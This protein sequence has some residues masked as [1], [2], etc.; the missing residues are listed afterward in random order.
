MTV[1]DKLLR[2]REN[3]DNVRAAALARGKKE[4][5]ETGRK[6]EYDAFWDAYQANG[7]LGVYSGAF[8]YYGWTDKAFKPKYDIRPIYGARG[9]FMYTKITDICKCLRDCG[10]VF[11]SSKASDLVTCFAHTSSKSIPLVDVTGLKNHS[12]SK[13]LFD[14]RENKGILKY[15]E[16]VVVKEN[17]QYDYWFAGCT[18]LESVTF[19]GSI[20]NNLSMSDCAML[21]RE[22][23][24]SVISHLS[25]T[26]SGKTLTLS[27]TAV[28]SAFDGEEIVLHPYTIDHEDLATY[29]YTLTD[30][31]DG[32][33]T[34]NGGVEGDMLA[35]YFKF[36]EGQLPA[37][38]Y[39]VSYLHEGEGVPFGLHVQVNEGIDIVFPVFSGQS[40]RFTIRDGDTLLL[41][42]D[43]QS[44]YT[45]R[46]MKPTLKRLTW[47]SLVASKQNWAITLV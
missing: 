13:S 27:D 46:K 41:A 38:V 8:S 36:F 37:G 7:T 29:G 47:E 28:E 34:V 44:A 12:N 31:G 14:H 17:T 25:D 24:E 33:V 43:L 40:E 15:I 21:S 32:S 5:F 20:A 1:S 42:M 45:N 26:A 39:E 30:N 19:Q 9:T 4:G 16:G 35:A 3:F 10:V 11:D 6:S 18:T 23:I 22:S 2:E